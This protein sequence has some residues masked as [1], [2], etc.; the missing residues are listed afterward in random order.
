MKNE[1]RE[2]ITDVTGLT[3]TWTSNEPTASTAQTIANGSAV[4]ST[5]T[6][7]AI[8]NLNARLAAVIAK[9]NS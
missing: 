9:I 4:T 1:Q 6:G 7:Q 8:A 3:I 2:Y 5:E